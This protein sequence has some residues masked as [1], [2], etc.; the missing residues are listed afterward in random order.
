MSERGIARKKE[1]RKKKQKSSRKQTGLLADKDR[2][3]DRSEQKRR[4]HRV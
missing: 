4:G 1:E 2:Q 3:T